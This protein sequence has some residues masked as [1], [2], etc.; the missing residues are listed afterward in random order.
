MLTIQQPKLL[1]REA[2]RR[3]PPYEKGVAKRFRGGGG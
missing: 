3:I 2:E 1:A